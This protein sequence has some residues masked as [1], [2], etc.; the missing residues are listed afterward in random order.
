MSIMSILDTTIKSAEGPHCSQN[1]SKI[2]ILQ[3]NCAR[4]TNARQ[5]CLDTA[6]ESVNIVL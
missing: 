3:Y 5:F 2:K 1:K 6:T 4:S